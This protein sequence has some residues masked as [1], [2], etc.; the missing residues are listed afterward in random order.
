[1]SD[2]FDADGFRKA[3]LDDSTL[4]ADVK[5]HV[6]RMFDPANPVTIDLLNPEKAIGDYVASSALP[7]SSQRHATKNVPLDA[8]H[9]V[10]KMWN[11]VWQ[12][13]LKHYAGEAVQ[14]E[15]A[16]N[17]AG[18]SISDDPF[19]YPAK[20]PPI[21]LDTHTP[22]IN[23]AAGV[24]VVGNVYASVTTDFLNK[25]SPDEQR[26]ILFHEAQHAFEPVLSA[27]DPMAFFVGN[28][29][30]SLLTLN[31][32]SRRL[33]NRADAHAA[34]MGDAKALQSGLGKLRADGQQFFLNRR[35]IMRHLLDH[36]FAIDSHNLADIMSDVHRGIHEQ[37]PEL[38]DTISNLP[39]A[40][41]RINMAALEKRLDRVNT[42]IKD[43][44]AIEPPS[45]LTPIISH[46]GRVLQ[47]KT[48]SHPDAQKR[49]ENLSHAPTCEGCDP[50]SPSNSHAD[51]LTQISESG[52]Q[53]WK[54]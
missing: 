5:R 17:K 9:P 12:Q 46:V 29:V 25:L 53:G 42:F 3:I 16:L 23:A 34:N 22:L 44:A 14:Y 20:T 1:M 21:S 8:H 47:R 31:A 19:R 43:A 2:G 50:K 32:A 41:S 15:Q 28:A 39:A 52:L 24:G 13:T 40:H 26:A 11:E 48:S 33:E 37:H 27:Q 18:R 7:S 49:I 4:G 10:A 6:R 35:N 45:R 30:K 54:R 36:G 51:R 38:A